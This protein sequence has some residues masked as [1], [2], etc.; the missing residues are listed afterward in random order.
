MTIPRLAVPVLLGAS[1]SACGVDSSATVS[2]GD[3]RG[4]T[5]GG[6]SSVIV[7]VP[8]IVW[9]DIPGSGGSG[10]SCDPDTALV[11]CGETGGGGSVSGPPPC[12]ESGALAGTCGALTDDQKKRISAMIS[13][14]TN[15]APLA[16]VLNQTLA[17]GKLRVV[18][19]I[20][21]S[22]TTEAV[23]TSDP[24]RGLIIITTKHWYASGDAAYT[25]ALRHEGGHLLYPKG[26]NLNGVSYSSEQMAQ[27]HGTCF[28]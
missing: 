21:R 11:P 13:S 15:C 20:P 9:T 19:S 27:K 16:D 5:N 14:I 8:E 17:A 10:S 25:A 26:S 23:A 1:L 4:E 3:A 6:L 28:Q 2:K 22:P 18:A 24:A 12:T 7:N